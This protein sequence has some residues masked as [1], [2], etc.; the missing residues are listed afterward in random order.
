MFSMYEKD[1]WPSSLISVLSRVLWIE[2]R[3]HC[4]VFGIL[5]FPLCLGNEFIISVVSES[6]FDEAM[7][8]SLKIG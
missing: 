3:D 1:L 8:Q 7:I 5:V 2:C 6:E 4:S